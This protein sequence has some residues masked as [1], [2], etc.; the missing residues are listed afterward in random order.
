MSLGIMEEE[1]LAEYFRLQYGERLLQMLQK[2]PN[3]QGQSESPSIR[4]LEKKKETKIM[5]HNMLQKK[6]MFQRRME[7]LNLR[8]EELGVKEAQ[9]KAHIQKFEQ[10]IQEND[11]KRIRAMKKANKERELK[12]Q[13]MQE[14]SKG[15]QEMVA[16]RLE[17]QRLSAKLQD[18]SIFNKYLEKVVENSEFE[19]IHEVIARYKTLVS[20]HHDLMQSAQEGQEKI[21]RAKARLARYMEEKDDE[22]LQQNNELARLQMRFDHA[23][24]NVIIWESRWA[25]IQNTAA[26]KT[27][28]LGTIKMAT[29]NLFQIVSKQLKE[30][31]E[32]ALEDTHKQ[33]D[34]IQQFI[35]DLSDIWAEVKKKEQQ[36]VRV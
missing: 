4:L 3:V 24:S 16:L 5:H 33:L 36:Q 35:Q 30:V 10:F 13:H 8:W 1:D 23:R 25:H 6:K 22:I 7:T 2:L 31:T 11:Q 17:H 32:V 9:L 15:K 19:E 34:M 28:L 18:Y 26:K 27:L 14:L 29:L 21:E 12:R 20:M